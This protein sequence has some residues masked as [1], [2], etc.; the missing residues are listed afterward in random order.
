MQSISL[1]VLHALSYP[2]VVLS[3]TL[4]VFFKN[5]AFQKETAYHTFF[6]SKTVQYK[7][8]QALKSENFPAQIS[9][10]NYPKLGEKLIIRI[11]KINQ[12]HTAEIQKYLCTLEISETALPENDIFKYAIESSTDLLLIH[13]L[14]VEV[15]FVSKAFKTVL[16][17]EINEVKDK[18]IPDFV[19]PEYQEQ[20]RE[21][22]KKCI[23]EMATEASLEFK[24][25]HK[26]GT[27]MWLKSTVHVMYNAHNEV[28]G[29]QTL[30]R[31]ITESKKQ[32][33]QILRGYEEYQ[34]LFDKNPN[35]LLIVSLENGR[36]L[37]VNQAASTM[38]GY[39]REELLKKYYGQ[40]RPKEDIDGFHQRR[41]ES[42]NNSYY[43]YLELKHQRKNGEI[44]YIN[45]YGSKLEYEGEKCDL[46]LLVD[47]SYKVVAEKEIKELLDAEQKASRELR[48]SED[49]L[50]KSLNAYQ[51]LNI[52]L[53]ESELKFRTLSENAPIGIYLT[54]PEGKCIWANKRLQK[55]FDFGNGEDFMKSWTSRIH[56]EDYKKSVKTWLGNARK[57]QTS[58][59]EYR[60]IVNQ[61]VKYL[62]TIYSPIY[63]TASELIGHV[64][65]LEDLTQRRE[66]QIQLV[67]NAQFRELLLET[68]SNFV[69]MN[70]E[71]IDSQIY[72]ALDKVASFANF[73]Y[74]HI[75]QINEEMTQTKVYYQYAAPQKS[76]FSEENLVFETKKYT[77]WLEQLLQNRTIEA[78]S[79][80]DFPE[81]AVYERKIIKNSGAKSMFVVPMFFQGRLFGHITFF[82]TQHAK[83]P[84]EDSKKILRLLAQILSNLFYRATI[85]RQLTESE[86]LYRLLA[87]NTTDLVTLHDTKLQYHYVSP[88]VKTMIGYEA[89]DLLGKSSLEFVHPDDQALIQTKIEETLENTT[90]RVTYRFL[91]KEGNY[92]WIESN[93]RIVR[94]PDSGEIQ[95]LIVSRDV[96]A[97]VE[98]TRAL[99]SSQTLLATIFDESTDAILVIS[100]DYVIEDCNQRT[101][102]LFEVEAKEMILGKKD[103]QLEIKSESSTIIQKAYE[104][105]QQQEQQVTY[106]QVKYKTFKGNFFWANFASK[107]LKIEGE[108]KILITLTDITPITEANTRIEEL[109][110]NAH[111]L[112][113]KLTKQ[114]EELLRTNQELDNFVYSVSHDLRAPLTSAMG[115]IEIS[116]EEKSLET[117]L[118][119]LSLQEKSLKKLDGFIHEIVDYS[120]NSRLTLKPSLIDFQTLIQDSLTQLRFMEKKGEIKEILE[121]EPQL[122]FYSD[123]GRLEIIFGNLLSNAIRYSDTQKN[124]SFVKIQVT[125]TPEG[126]KIDVSDNGQG[127]EE[128][129]QQRVF[130]MFYR[131]TNN[132]PGSGLGL[133]ILK[134]ALKKIKGQVELYSKMG[135]GTTFTLFLPNLEIN[136]E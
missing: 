74:V 135:Q 123:K 106:R 118:Y 58:Q 117:V 20:V 31:D 17:Y 7:L 85:G 75:H 33:E 100:E 80:D 90:A 113:E 24:G 8:S 65:S 6:E 120:R 25:L 83:L 55:L 18:N 87:D 116:K 72:Q 99:K 27:E 42:K 91:H 13:N 15:I 77:W 70:F 73:D 103:S 19:H 88:T 35:P 54:D 101:L 89:G 107:R 60:I 109:L 126:V 68:F 81:D 112:N 37:K 50:R 108:N 47:I 127:I 133:Y 93:G 125:K 102:E 86:N 44:F 16:G 71:E 48:I 92:I 124:N 11:D 43:Q 3:N 114:N 131:A 10:S 79:E 38:Y 121:V 130:D 39:S 26:N 30:L 41:I 129:H 96:S 97:R 52:Q 115:L 63:N 57:Q 21:F 110:S 56:P 62:K 32:R 51:E 119:Y 134:E 40:L 59:Q 111:Q 14:S 76:S 104:Q 46:I 5:K 95:L 49:G 122:D 53:Q 22:T 23:T 105:V 66:A 2:T 12:E 132:K 67:Y 64:G 34:Y 61:E 94:N 45:A 98:V 28:I 128:I 84:N 9:L 36:L 1:E 78:T 4:D 136:N 69:N 29:F 82:S